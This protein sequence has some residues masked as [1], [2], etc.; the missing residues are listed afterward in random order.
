MAQI[1]FPKGKGHE[2]T[3]EITIHFLFVKNVFKSHERSSKS[4]SK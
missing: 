4:I 1:R 3:K 2:K